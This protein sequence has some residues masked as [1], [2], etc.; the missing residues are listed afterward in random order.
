MSAEEDHADNSKKELELLRARVADL[1]ILLR[2]RT[3]EQ[4][5]RAFAH[6]VRWGGIVLIAYFT[7]G[8]LEQFA[9]KTSFAHIYF[10]WLAEV[11]ADLPRWIA[12]CI[13]GAGAGYGLLERRLRKR[14]TK[15]LAKRAQKLEQMIDSTRSSSEISPTGETLEEDNP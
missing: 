13:G 12:Y 14:K 9:G 3:G 11:K 2:N 4:R 7:M 10:A 1:E 6:L 8:A 15:Y 5:L